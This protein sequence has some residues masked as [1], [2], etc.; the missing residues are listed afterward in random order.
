MTHD[1]QAAVLAAAHR[2]LRTPYR[3]C[4]AV[5]GVGVDC[6]ML[7]ACVY[8]EAGLIP[9][10]D[11]RPYPTDW[12][13]HRSEERY[14]LGLGQYA[15]RLPDDKPPAPGDIQ[16]MQFGRTMSHAAIVTHWPEIIHAYQPAG[17]VTLGRADEAA[18]ERRLGPRYR[19]NIG[20]PA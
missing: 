14:L 19:V 13:Q 12:M 18:F 17:M 4:A 8:H 20:A 5:H 1:Q 11:P 10:V 6:L 16:M 15:T 9:W 7:L 2:W 3:H